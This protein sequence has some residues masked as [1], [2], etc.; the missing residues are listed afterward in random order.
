MIS[1][2]GE[3]TVFLLDILSAPF[4]VA[5]PIGDTGATLSIRA[6][7]GEA[8][9]NLDLKKSVGKITIVESETEIEITIG[10]RGPTRIVR[11]H[12]RSRV[13]Q[14]RIQLIS[15]SNSPLKPSLL[16][17]ALLFFFFSF[18]V[19]KKKKKQIFIVVDWI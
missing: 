9:H 10:A 18:Y 11:V 16:C 1:K 4:A 12:L 8:T 19:V 14:I 13:E 17:S 15:H 6:A 7:L 5:G 2:I 3:Q